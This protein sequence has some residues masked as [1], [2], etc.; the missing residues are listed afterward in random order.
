[1]VQ[2]PVISLAIL[3]LSRL[4]AASL[5]SLGSPCL[6]DRAPVSSGTL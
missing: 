4:P 1:M 3:N 5:R 2:M 6:L